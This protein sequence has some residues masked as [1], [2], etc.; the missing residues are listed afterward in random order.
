M[1]SA[2][3]HAKPPH[4][5]VAVVRVN[6]AAIRLVFVQIVVMVVATN[7]VFSRPALRFKVRSRG[8]HRSYLTRLSVRAIA[9]NGPSKPSCN[10]FPSLSEGQGLSTTR[11]HVRYS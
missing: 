4:V 2:N 7:R 10:S 3:V 11:W 6:V 8:I 1:S 5:I 9:I